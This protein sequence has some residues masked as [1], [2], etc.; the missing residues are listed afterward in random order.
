M[1]IKKYVD[2]ILKLVLN[3]LKYEN[4]FEVELVKPLRLGRTPYKTTKLT[5]SFCVYTFLLDVLNTYF[6]FDVLNK[7][8]KAEFIISCY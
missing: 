5:G 1:V 4:V 3:I 6:L 8:G 2:N 7:S